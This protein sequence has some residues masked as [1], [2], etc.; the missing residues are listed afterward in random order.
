MRTNMKMQRKEVKKSD[1]GQDLESCKLERLKMTAAYG[2][3]PQAEAWAEGI[4]MQQVEVG[5]N[6]VRKAKR[7]GSRRHRRLVVSRA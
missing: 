3:V 4:K 5:C 6:V 1:Q 7:P 2:V